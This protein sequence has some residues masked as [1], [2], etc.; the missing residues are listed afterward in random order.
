MHRPLHERPPATPT[1]F[2]LG[3]PVI[4]LS[5]V[6]LPAALAVLAAMNDGSVLL[7][8]DEPIQRWVEAHR[9]GTLDPVFRGFSRLGSNVVVFGVLGALLVLLARRCPTLALALA[10]AVLARPLFEFVVKAAVDRP[11]PDLEPLIP[12]MGASHPS[13]HVLAAMTLWGLLPPIVATL[14]HRRFWWW[15]SAG[16][17]AVLIVGIAASR[18]YLGVHWFSDVVGGIL[19]GVLYIVAVETLFVWHHR[20]RSCGLTHGDRASAPGREAPRSSSE[21]Q[22]SMSGLSSPA[23]PQD[24]RNIGGDERD[25]RRGHGG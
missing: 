14:T 4:I 17:G 3:H 23:G 9:S 8:W 22:P 16:A 12:G 19:L 15:V 7:T 24:P 25:D 1:G 10:A 21:P 18:V 11:R 20:H 5:I 6:A 13:G 2:V